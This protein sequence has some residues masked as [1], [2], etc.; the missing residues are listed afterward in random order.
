MTSPV[1]SKASQTVSSIILIRG[2]QMNT[3]ST[4]HV[5][6]SRARIRPQHP[7]KLLRALE[8]RYLLTCLT[9]CTLQLYLKYRIVVGGRHGRHP[10]GTSSFWVNSVLPHN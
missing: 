9:K 10:W 2:L 8:V 7:M 6:L 4:E 3:Q 5:L 1:L